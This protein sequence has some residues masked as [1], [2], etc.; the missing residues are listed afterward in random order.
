MK[1]LLIKKKKSLIK[2]LLEMPFQNEDLIFLA[3]Q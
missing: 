2:I 3:F 1:Q